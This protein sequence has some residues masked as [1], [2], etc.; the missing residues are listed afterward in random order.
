MAER[1]GAR[2]LPS[3]VGSRVLLRLPVPADV[4]VRL[5]IPPDPEE[6][7][8]MY[9]AEGAPKA[10]TREEVESGLAQYTNQDPDVGR[11]FV[12]AARVWPNGQAIFDLVGRYIGV[13]RLTFISREHGHARLVVSIFDRRF[14]SHGYGTEAIRLLLRYGFDDLALHRVDLVVLDYNLRAIRSYEK[15]GF[16]REG[17]FRETIKVDGVWRSD[18]VMAILEDEFRAQPWATATSEEV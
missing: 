12:I 14:W 18:L 11:R 6:E 15:C 10:L 2:M 13:I 1:E 7:R 9:G 3:L 16:V 17:I 5:E 8:M 4:D